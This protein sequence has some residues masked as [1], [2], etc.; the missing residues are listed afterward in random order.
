VTRSGSVGRATLAGKAITEFLISDDLLR[1]EIADPDWW[2]WVYAYLRSPTARSMMSAAQYG[3]IIKHLEVFHLEQ[4]PLVRPVRSLRAPFT[5][6]ARRIVE[7]RD[8]ALDLILEAEVELASR[9]GSPTGAESM[10]GFAVRASDLFRLGRRLDALRHNPTARAA[11]ASMQAKA[12]RLEP[13]ATLVDRVFIPGR[14][15]H[16]YG[17]EGTPYL[18]SAQILEVA[19]DI[20]KRVLSLGDE[21]K[22]GYLVERGTLLI[23]CSGQLHGII[24]SVV[25]AAEW[26]ESKVLTNHI[27]RIVPKAKPPIR[28]GYLQLVLGHPELGRPRLLKTAFGSS[29]PELDANE[30]SRLDIPRIEPDIEDRLGSMMEEAAA[31]LSEANA[32][33]ELVADEAER[34]IQTFMAGAPEQ[35]E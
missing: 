24:G 10:A 32:I 34:L 17:E 18:D 9:L 30:I 15:K 25:L 19:P 8:E 23:P 20:D 28:I 3:H 12:L 31:L 21:R 14:F 22:A 33:E 1:I 6:R 5:E 7:L 26:H 16:V 27:L 4:L 11:E 35:F 2:G 13:L 29:V